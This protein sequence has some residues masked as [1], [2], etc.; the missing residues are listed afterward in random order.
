MEVNSVE[1][2]QTNSIII[3]IT[4]LQEISAKEPSQ[5]RRHVGDLFKTA[6]HY[7]CVDQ[8]RVQTCLLNI[9]EIFPGPS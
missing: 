2:Y 5:Q 8:S 4:E 3:N 1:I 6:S 9:S 7:S